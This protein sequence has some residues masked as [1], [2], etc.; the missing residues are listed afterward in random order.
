[1]SSRFVAALGLASLLTVAAC[2]GDASA[3]SA[4]P[5]SAP[6]VAA[7]DAPPSEAPPSEPPSGTSGCTPSTDAAVVVAG[8]EDIAFL[9]ATVEARV[10]EVI[11]WTN[12]DSASHTATLTDDPSCTTD[13]LS[14]G[15]TGALVFSQPGSYPFF[16]RIHPTS[17]TG[18][19]EISE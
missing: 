8:M 12:S 1:M 15:G 3:P 6:S 16:C 2:S 7:S 10:G 19:I 14:R 9:P 5:T 11:A 4:A 18:T 17:M 13:V